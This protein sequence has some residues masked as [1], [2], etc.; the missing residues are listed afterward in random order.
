MSP[1]CLDGSGHGRANFPQHLRVEGANTLFFRPE[2]VP[3]RPFEPRKGG[4]RGWNGTGP[5]REEKEGDAG[6]WAEGEEHSS[7]SVFF[8]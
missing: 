3:L 7:R 5:A 1:V 8:C 6:A 4:W 2:I